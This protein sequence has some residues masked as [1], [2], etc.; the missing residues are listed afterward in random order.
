MT[1]YE[2]SRSE[3][4]RNPIKMIRDSPKMLENFTIR[5]HQFSPRFGNT[6]NT[7]NKHN[8]VQNV[9]KCSG[10]LGNPMKN[11]GILEILT[12][13]DHKLFTGFLNTFE[14]M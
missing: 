2:S 7:S 11:V 5:G 13:R 8:R 3:I 4:N 6:L 1:Y 9:P 10:I 12:I 14:Y